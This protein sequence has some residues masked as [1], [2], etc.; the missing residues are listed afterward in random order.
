MV[1]GPTAGVVLADLGADVIKVEPVGGDHTRTLLGSGAGYFPMFHRNKRS[2]CLDLK[3]PDV[4][5]AAR[6]LID[7]ADVVI[8]NFRPAALKR[9]GLG[10]AIFD[11]INQG[12]IYCSA[13]GFLSGPFALPPPPPQH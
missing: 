6:R 11:D 12:P 1:M 7:G 3:S 4:L 8:E 5:I 10:L 13:T 9:L 2:I